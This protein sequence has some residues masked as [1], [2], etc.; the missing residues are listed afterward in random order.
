LQRF[1]EKKLKNFQK[2]QEEPKKKGTMEENRQKKTPPPKIQ[3]HHKG[4]E[5]VSNPTI[6]NKAKRGQKKEKRNCL[7]RTK[8]VAR[9]K[10]ERPL[11][12]KVLTRGVENKNTSP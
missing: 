8:E 1:I 5:K 7:Q 4:E 11:R 2:K 10:R 3:K 9:T 12:G 6:A